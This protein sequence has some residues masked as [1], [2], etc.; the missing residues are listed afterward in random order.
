[1]AGTPTATMTI[2]AAFQVPA[3]FGT[4]IGGVNP[5][6]FPVLAAAEFDSWLTVGPT[7]GT[8]GAAIS[9]VGL[10]FDAWTASAGIS[11]DNGAIF[12]MSP[13]DGPSGSA[14]LAQITNSGSGSASASLQGRS[15]SGGDWTE[16]ISWSW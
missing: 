6:F 7:D 2:P 1:M 4:H 3:P 10:D 9:S 15:A 11:A 5:A 16:V 8:A 12:W 14:V 13:D